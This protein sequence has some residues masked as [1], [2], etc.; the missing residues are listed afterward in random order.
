MAVG[1]QGEMCCVWLD[2]RNEQTEVMSSISVDGGSRWSKN[3]LVYKSPDG[4]VCE[5]CHPS[6]AFNRQGDFVAMWRNSL[7]GDRDM[8]F[9]TSSDGGKT[10]GKA[11]KL[12]DGSWSLDACPM[13]G[14]S[15]AVAPSGK[16]V[17][18][19][20]RDNDIYLSPFNEAKE[21][22]LGSGEQPWIAATEA[23]PYLVWS[24][25]RGE[26]A[27]LLTPGKVTPLEL[28]V[29]A[30]YPVIAVGPTGRGPVVA[31]WETREG[32]NFSIQCQVV[33]EPLSK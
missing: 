11:T 29:H 4:S 6:V 10:F 24:K 9:A 1:P 7:D 31:A 27:Y 26:V 32:K 33:S 5:C 19:W 15:L 23:G 30:S 8:Y 21:R 14:G 13:D 3:S 2:L 25:K 17:T 16:I 18:V 28:G 12:G 22:L 20:R